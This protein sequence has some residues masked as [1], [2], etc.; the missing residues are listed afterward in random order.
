MASFGTVLVTLPRLL[1]AYASAHGLDGVAIA[2]G[3][4]LHPLPAGNDA[5]VPRE[6]VDALFERLTVELGDPAL[7]LHLATAIPAG[8]TGVLEVVTQTAPNVRAA[9]RHLTRYWKLINDGVDVRVEETDARAELTLRTVA[10]RPLARAWTDLTVVAL[11]VQGLRSVTARAPLLYVALP[12]PEDAVGRDV[13]ALVS[14]ATGS[15]CDAR[16][17]ADHVAIGIRADALD[18][19]LLNEN[20]A[21]HAIATQHAESLLAEHGEEGDWLSTVRRAIHAHLETG[22]ANVERIAKDARTSPRTLQRQLQAAGTSLRALIE[23]ARRDIAVREL[24]TTDRSITDL[25][26]L[27]GFSETSAFDRAFRR[28]TGKTPLAYRAERGR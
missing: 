12:Y 20:A 23:E 18:A 5:R 6:R 17:D 13:I 8:N 2:E 3:A 26:F 24:S 9:L 28:W 22:D 11:G 21:L 16:F 14:A 4:G 27:L 1:L 15:R 10:P 25:A 19:P 7:G